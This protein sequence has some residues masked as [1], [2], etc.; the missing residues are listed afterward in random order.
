LSGV[1]E[2]LSG[3]AAPNRC[4]AEAF[5][6]AIEAFSEV[7]E[8]LSEAVEALSGV[9]APNGCSCEAFCFFLAPIWCCAGAFAC[10]GTRA[11]RCN[12]GPNRPSLAVLLGDELARNPFLRYNRISVQKA[13]ELAPGSSLKCD[14]DVFSALRA[15]KNVF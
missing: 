9:A 7:A 3:V 12:I 14:R 2:A 5:S 1:A 6:E 15:W 4:A 11:T 8:A 10:G 13:A